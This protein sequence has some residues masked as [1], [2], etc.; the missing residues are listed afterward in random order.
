MKYDVNKCKQARVNSAG[1]N[2]YRRSERGQDPVLS[3]KRNLLH[4]PP[5]ASHHALMRM[6]TP[7]LAQRLQEQRHPTVQPSLLLFTRS[8]LH[9][10]LISESV[11][12]LSD[13]KTYSVRRSAPPSLESNHWSPTELRAA[14]ARLPRWPSTTGHGSIDSRACRRADV[15]LQRCWHR[16]QRASAERHHVCVSCSDRSG[17]FTSGP[18]GDAARPANVQRAAGHGLHRRQQARDNSSRQLDH[19]LHGLCAHRPMPIL[20]V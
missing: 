4:V 17:S 15:P 19:L 20:D 2:C 8:P 16:H 10:S 18:W 12:K 9:A 7:G 11:A 1:V 6:H 13:S 5:I 3:S 14:S